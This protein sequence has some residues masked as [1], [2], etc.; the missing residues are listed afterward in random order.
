MLKIAVIQRFL[1]SLSRGGVGYFTHGL[2]N[3]LC[4]RSHNVTVFSQDPAPKDALYQVTRVESSSRFA[5]L[6]FPFDVARQDFSS[7]DLIHAQ[8]DDQFISRKAPPVIRTLHGSS[9]SEAIHNGLIRLSPKHF[10]LHMYFYFFEL[11]SVA[12]AHS[13][14][15]VSKQTAHHYWKVDGVISNGI[16]VKQFSRADIFKSKSPSILFV[17]DLTN[18]KRGNL[19][20]D[21]YKSIIRPKVPEAELWMVCPQKIDEP[22]VRTFDHVTSEKLSELYASAWVFCLP[23][24]YE[25]FGRPYIEAMAAGTPVVATWNPGAIEVLDNGRFGIITED[26]QLGDS[27]VTLLQDSATRVKLSEL[28]LERAQQ[29]DWEQIVDQYEKVYRKVLAN[30]KIP[31]INSVPS[32]LP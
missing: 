20:L 7:F 27:L 23:S 19:L 3:A 29:Y 26:N 8:G 4:N 2:C 28:G 21:T 12:K 5:P 24:S 13:V 10:L 16:D 25:G 32:V 1:P 14:I 17:G 6:S 22:G 18:R 31:S 11:L 9:L 15:T 30:K